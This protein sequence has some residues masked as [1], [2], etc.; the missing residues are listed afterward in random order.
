[1]RIIIRGLVP[2]IF[3]LALGVVQFLGSEARAQSSYFSSRGC[4][5]CHGAPVAAS[6]KG[7][8]HHGASPLSGATNK[9]SYAPGETVTVTINSGSRTGWVRTILYDQNNIQVAISSGNESG[10]GSS[11]LLPSLLSAPAPS[12]PGTY[13]WQAAYFGNED[14]NGTGDV[15]SEVR[16]NTNSFT[17]TGAPSETTPP[18][19][20]I[21]TLANGA[22][23]NNA[24]LNVTGT[25]S[26]AS[27]IAG[28]TVNGAAVTVTGGAFSTALPLISGANTI[29]T[30][31]TDNVGNQTTDTR[32]INLDQAGPLLNVNSPADNSMIKQSFVDVTGTVSENSTVTVNGA[33]AAMNGLNFSANVNLIAGLNTIDITATDLGG[34]ISTLKRSV[35]SDPVA[36]SLAVTVPS[37][38]ITSTTASNTI[39]GTVS[40]ALTA[41]TVTITA[42]GKSY[43][44]VVAGGS[45]TQAITLSAS[46]TYAVIVTA[47]DEAGNQISV[48]RNIIFTQS[49][50]GDINGDSKT[51][52]QDALMALKLSVNLMPMNNSYM[53]QGD[54]APYVNGHSQPDGHIDI[55]DALTIL[56]MAV[57]LIPSTL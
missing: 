20:T 30:I 12:T 18:A 19:L 40:D 26:D 24:T 3:M 8:H 54:V 51:D 38:D 28:V 14:G 25:A 44:P 32:T 1:M 57:S 43:T 7:C 29:T 33:G 6:C 41:V 21:S 55:S 56:K 15:H 9:V 48:T 49:S 11:T 4:T 2:F 35:T 45:F 34:N 52:I 22:V 5:S 16:V 13:T 50:I 10:M 17:V 46:N 36:P 37:Q 27:G 53:A 31:A 23:T 42:D 39:S 47:T